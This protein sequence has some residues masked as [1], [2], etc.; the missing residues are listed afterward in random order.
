MDGGTVVLV[1]REGL[2][3]VG[4]ADAKFGIEMFDRFL[5]TLEG[6][7]D[8]PRAMC[9]YTDGVKLVRKDS[10]VV[11]SLKLIEGLGTRLVVCKT[12]LEYFGLKDRVAVGTVGGM[13]DIVKLL[14]EADHVV[15]I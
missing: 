5:H 4:G 14:M 13:N 3:S 11:M 8:R 9:F 15:T 6:R 10:P 1:T 7:T 2:G 12:C